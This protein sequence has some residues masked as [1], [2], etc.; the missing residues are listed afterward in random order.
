VDK[1]TPNGPISKRQKTNTRVRAKSDNS[2]KEN[3]ITQTT[4]STKNEKDCKGKS[5]KAETLEKE[6]GTKLKRKTAAK[7][8]D[9]KQQETVKGKANCKQMTISQ[10]GTL[11]SPDNQLTDEKTR[12]KRSSE[13]VTKTES[14]ETPEIRSKEEVKKTKATEKESKKDTKAGKQKTEQ[15][16]SVVNNE[17]DEKTM[18]RPRRSCQESKTESE[19]I[20]TEKTDKEQLDKSMEKGP[21]VDKNLVS[22]PK[23]QPPKPPENLEQLK[24]ATCRDVTL[25]GKTRHIYGLVSTKMSKTIDQQ[26]VTNS[27]ANKKKTN[28]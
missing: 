6:A 10:T 26:I 9:E 21:S 23:A 19:N 27:L 28:K 24:V 5:P 8:V 3:T 13:S 15:R 12:K 20:E 1:T 14:E 18:R 2:E 25:R 17:L 22:I 16:K 11:E 4:A 7:G